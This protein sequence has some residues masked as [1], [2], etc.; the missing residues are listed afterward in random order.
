MP[1]PFDH[2]ELRDWFFE[3]IDASDM[4]PSAIGSMGSGPFEEIEFDEF[5]E[6]LAIRP[7]VPSA[8]LNVLIVGREG[9]EKDLHGTIEQRRGKD[10][11]VYSQEMLLAY[12]ATNIDP[13]ESPEVAEIFGD[14]HPALEYIRE[15]G[16]EWPVTRLVP[17]T[18]TAGALSTHQWREQSILKLLGYTVGAK[19]LDKHQRQNT[20]RK[21][22]LHDLRGI[23]DDE[24]VIGWGNPQSG[25][26]LQKIAERLSL[27]ITSNISRER[28]Q[29]A[30]ADWRED[31]AWLKQEHYDGKHTFP[32]PSQQVT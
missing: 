11:Q 15:W 19:G 30:V 21:A 14:G 13:L 22:Y 3:G 28:Q 29:E 2:D 10:L 1:S 4:F 9:W 8:D 27:N 7:E 20:L 5:L 24:Y 17:S 26:R 23:A 6:T 16:F 25:L 12:I 32:W 18:P 31:L